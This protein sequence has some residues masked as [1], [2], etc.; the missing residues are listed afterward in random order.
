VP[1][2]GPIGSAGIGQVDQGLARDHQDVHRRLGLDIAEGDAQVI[3]VDLVRGE[4]TR[5]MRPKIVS[6]LGS[7]AAGVGWAGLVQGWRRGKRGGG[8]GL[9]AQALTAQIC[10]QNSG[11]PWRWSAWNRGGTCS[12]NPCS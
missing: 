5:R 2:Q 4:L 1:Q 11:G 8:Q 6:A 12:L 7:M 3:A 9:G 10:R